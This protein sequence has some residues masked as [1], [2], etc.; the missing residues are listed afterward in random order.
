MPAWELAPITW[1]AAATLTT[2]VLAV[3]AAIWVGHRQ[4]AISDK[5]TVIAD[6]MRN[7]E[8]IKIKSD[9]FDRRMEVY[10]ATYEWLC[11]WYIEGEVPLEAKTAFRLARRQSG[12][13]FR[14]EL[15]EELNDWSE[16]AHILQQAMKDDPDVKPVRKAKE[17]EGRLARLNSLFSPD[18]QLPTPK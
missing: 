17:W 4:L 12:F 7:L 6:E 10:T 3:G 18:L 16:R 2:G 14:P 8:V 13:L 9:L 5:Q 15:A 1:E 11:Y